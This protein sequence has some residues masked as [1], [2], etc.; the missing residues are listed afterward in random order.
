M[1]TLFQAVLPGTILVIAAIA[2]LMVEGFAGAGRKATLALILSLIGVAGAFLA[3]FQLLNVNQAFF[4][5][6]LP[7]SDAL[8]IDDFGIVLGLIALIGTGFSLLIS[9]SQLERTKFNCPEYYA[10]ILLAAAGMIF[11]AISGD[12]I[13][14]LLSLEIMS[15]AIYIL[16]GFFRDQVK[17]NEAAIKYFILGAFSTG[18][19]LFGMA[20]VYGV[21][22]TVVISQISQTQD[23]TILLGM[24]LM[25]VGFFF[26]I[27]AVPFHSW[28]PD[29]YEGAP[30]SVTA[31]MAVGVKTAGFAVF[32]R[33][34]L[35]AFGNFGDDWTVVIQVVAVLSMIIGNVVAISQR[36][37]KRLLAY[38]SI[39][40]TGYMLLA[41][42]AAKSDPTMG[43]TG[44][45][46]YLLTY[47]FT[48]SGAFAAIIA[49]GKEN[50][51]DFAG[52]AHQHKLMGAAMAIFFFS[53]AGIPTTAG[54]MGKLLVFMTAID[55]HLYWPSII[56]I[57]TSIV[58][59]Y[60]YLR[61]VVYLYF[62]PEI[63]KNTRPPISLSLAI[64]STLAV[65]GVF[66]IG[67]LP[68]H[69]ISYIMLTYQA[70][71]SQ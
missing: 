16:A 30:T 1:I 39:A 23:K 7:F 26:K 46:F 47:T 67:L 9:P 37:L 56:G 38:S 31:F 18:F 2:V 43:S 29:V 55:Q 59:V 11:M 61:V 35:I 60:Y 4:P 54:F 62:Q 49:A 21:S 5:D 50:I 44:I 58:S 3:Q 24:G 53:L 65:V 34:M 51:E 20:I 52:Y 33:V 27:G 64:A 63:E 68:Q 25:L 70:M 12:L 48:V 8:R 17:S 45:V 69:F 22:G 32:L 28:V 19:L 42:A 10:L 66:V 13:T 41:F 71:I 6:A 15:L 14:F 40:H 57:I 36:N